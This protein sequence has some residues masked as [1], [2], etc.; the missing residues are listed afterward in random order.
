MLPAEYLLLACAHD[1]EFSGRPQIITQELVDKHEGLWMYRVYSHTSPAAVIVRIHQEHLPAC[2]ADVEHDLQQSRTG[3]DC[4]HSPDFRSVRWFGKGYSFSAI[5]SDAVEVL[6]E[7]WE[8]AT[9]EVGQ[10]YILQKIGS[11]CDHLKDVFKRHEAWGTMIQPG[12]KRGA[13]R[14]AEIPR[15]KE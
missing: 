1:R 12:P 5:Q 6:W 3:R 4:E 14:L 7:A 11:D 2:L 8:N 9:P 10:S 13:F 15:K